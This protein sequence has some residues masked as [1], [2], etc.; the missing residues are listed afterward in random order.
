M[1]DKSF[2]Y[3]MGL[4][5]LFSSIPTSLVAAACG[6]MSGLAYRSDL[7]NFRHFTFPGFLVRFA[8]RYIAPLLT[9]ASDAHTPSP[10]TRTQSGG[11]LGSQ[12]PAASA[13]AQ[14]GFETLLPAENFPAAVQWQQ[15]QPTVPPA[16]PPPSEEDVE[17]LMG[18]G[19][20][21][22]DVT[23]ALRLSGNNLELATNMLLDQNG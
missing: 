13:P 16:A 22:R 9:G 23:E 18:M 3:L 4:Q 10:N 20:N 7:V 11:R 17:T 1:T 6:L 2:T 12:F 14:G 5:L 19:F 15:Q 8:S 21:R